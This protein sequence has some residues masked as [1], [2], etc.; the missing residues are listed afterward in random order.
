V[1]IITEIVQIKDKSTRSGPQFNNLSTVSEGIPA[2]GWVLVEKT[3]GPYVAEARSASEFYSNRILK[4]FKGKDATQTDWVGAFHGFLVNLQAYIKK[5]H[6]TEL[7]W[8]GKGDA[9]ANAASSSSATGSSS[10][11]PPPPGG[12]PPPGPP[13]VSQ[14]STH[15]NKTADP[16]AMF[17]ALSKGEAVTANLRKVKPEEKT[18]HRKPEERNALVPAKEAEEKEPKK[19]H[20]V[21][22]KKP[23]GPAKFALEGNKWVVENQKN[24]KS[25]EITETE[26]KQTVYIYQCEGSVIQIKGKV[27]TITVD[28][29]SKCA[30]VF[31][32]AIASVEVVNSKSIEVQVT[33]KVPSFAVDKTSGFNLYLSKNCLDAEITTAKSDAMNI[34]IPP[35]VEGQD[36]TEIPIPEQFKTVIRNKKL[37]TGPVRHE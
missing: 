29:C 2:L 33:G 27:N 30:I 37:V 8:S 1:K 10:K 25:I 34:S 24:N 19:S 23:V 5:N 3:P 32:S 22:G 31:D 12:V 7:T 28:E 18:K 21:R 17:A 16:S 26:V 15:T 14:T 4:E 36:P 35:D 13:P 6:T 9:L 20:D 11:P